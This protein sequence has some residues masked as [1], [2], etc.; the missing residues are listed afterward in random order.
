MESHDAEQ[1]KGP[2]NPAK[3]AR[4]KPIIIQPS[5]AVLPMYARG[6]SIVPV[7]PLTQSTM[8]KPAGPLTLRVY[9]GPDCKGTLYQDDGVSYDFQQGNYLR[10][11]SSCSAENSKLHIHV[12][13]HQGSYGAWWEEIAIEVYGW[14][15][16]EG[17]A[18]L[19]GEPVKTKWNSTT[20]AWQATIPDSGKGMELTLE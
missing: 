7:A 9:V 11:D 4:S 2:Q 1:K 12:G 14:P 13:P 8:D 15:V 19:A 20:H 5:V 16:S 17:H 18:R 6:G 10:I 3:A